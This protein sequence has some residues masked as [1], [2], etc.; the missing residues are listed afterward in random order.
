MVKPATIASAVGHTS[1]FTNPDFRELGRG[2]GYGQRMAAQIVTAHRMGAVGV[3]IYKG[4]FT[5]P[6]SKSLIEE[7]IRAYSDPPAAYSL[8]VGVS[9]TETLLIEVNDSYALGKDGR[10]LS[11][12]RNFHGALGRVTTGPSD[13][14]PATVTTATGSLKLPP[15][16]YANL[17]RRAR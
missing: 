14:T 3:K 1:V 13:R 17:L 2:P 8:D 11:W 15:A 5:Y 16:A 4:D 9:E 6:P 12:G 7:M 10:V